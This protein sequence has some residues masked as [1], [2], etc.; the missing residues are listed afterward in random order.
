M[1]IQQDSVVKYLI[2]TKTYPISQPVTRKPPQ[3]QICISEGGK[4][5]IHNFIPTRSNA[6]KHKICFKYHN[7]TEKF[8]QPITNINFH[9]K[10]IPC[11]FFFKELEERERERDEKQM[12]D[13]LGES[14]VHSFRNMKIWIYRILI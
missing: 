3:S 4:N 6:I 13:R 7:I 10:W 14:K 12:Y 11:L 1:M 8:N 9:W 5:T 2:H